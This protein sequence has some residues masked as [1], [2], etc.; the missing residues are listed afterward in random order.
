MAVALQISP[1][2]SLYI[3]DPQ[4]TETGRNILRHS[5]PLMTDLGFEKFTFKKLSERMGGSEITV[6]RYFENK[7]RLLLYLLS[8]Y[9]EWIKYSILLNLQ[10]LDESRDKLKM[11]IR[12]VVESNRRT[13]LV[14]Y[15]DEAKL[16]DLVIDESEKTFH[17]KD[18]DHENQ[19]GFFLT[20]KSLKS[21]IAGILLE[22]NPDYA[23]PNSLAS[24]ILEMSASLR[25]YARHLPSM[26]EVS[27]L[28]KIDDHICEFLEE[29]TLAAIA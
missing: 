3:R 18:V 21:E 11:A 26:S 2:S 23:F 7:H 15:I 29:L 24:T 27:D 5:I 6:Y 22:V 10:N 28:R 17:T 9:W 20:L 8:Y 1:S 13:P 12:T 19:E 4:S 14:D 25:F 16:F